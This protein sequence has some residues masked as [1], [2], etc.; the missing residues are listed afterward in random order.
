MLL[1]GLRV[2][3]LSTVEGTDRGRGALRPHHSCR[4]HGRSRRK[5]KAS[6][7]GPAALYDTRSAE[8]EGGRPMTLEVGCPGTCFH[9]S[10]PALILI[11]LVL[12][13]WKKPLEPTR[14]QSWTFASRTNSPQAT[15]QT[16]STCRCRPMI[17][18][19]C[20]RENPLS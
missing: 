9:A 8:L 17:P 1:R 14:G 19:I 13:I 10:A 3:P 15:F 11:L 7:R 6:K 4:T 2:R 12:A 5:R 16:L 18:K 20:R